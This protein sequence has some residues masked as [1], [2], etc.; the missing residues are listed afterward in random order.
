MLQRPWSEDTP[1]DLPTIVVGHDDA[2]RPLSIA[3]SALV[4]H[5]IHSRSGPSQLSLI[6][7][8]SSHDLS[9]RTHIPNPLSTHVDLL[10]RNWVPPSETHA[11]LFGV[12]RERHGGFGFGCLPYRAMKTG[13]AKP[14]WQP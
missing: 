7:L 6:N 5:W 8:S 4:V 13:S 1:I 12:V 9:A 10:L 2:V 11:N 3:S 14:F